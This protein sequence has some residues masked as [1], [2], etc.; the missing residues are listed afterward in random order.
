MLVFPI[1]SDEN[2]GV[3]ARDF[4]GKAACYIP[5]FL[6][7]PWISKEAA[8][9]MEIHGNRESPGHLRKSTEIYVI[10]YNFHFLFFLMEFAT[11]LFNVKIRGI[12]LG[13]TVCK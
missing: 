2:F 13:P 4:R 11:K 1:A 6:N 3:E 9:K 12:F 5:N 8:Q 10:T 7:F